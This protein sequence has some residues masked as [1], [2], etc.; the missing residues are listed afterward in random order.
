MSSR[1]HQHIIPASLVL[2]LAITVAVLSFTR[3]PAESFLFPRLISVV[4]LLL[5]IW[6]FLRAVLGLA[7]VGTGVSAA[8]FRTIAPGMLVMC[9][10]CFYAA[11]ALGFYVAGTAA[12]FVLYSW[13]DSHSHQALSSW[14]RRVVVTAIF[15]AVIYGLFSMLLKVQTPRGMFL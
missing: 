12:F 13:Y 2:A 14:V 11:K 1:L 10:Y 7:R 6:N 8:T 9:V 15:M 4:M 3:E 5:A